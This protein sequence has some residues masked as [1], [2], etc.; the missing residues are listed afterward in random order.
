MAFSLPLSPIWSNQRWKVKI[1]DRERLEPPHV[2]ILRGPKTW[3]LNL[4]TGRFLDAVPDPSEL[5]AELLAF[6]LEHLELLREKWDEMYPE[7]PVESD[8]ERGS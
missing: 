5:P 1:R 8:D 6:I 7:N 3:R 4:R 2:S